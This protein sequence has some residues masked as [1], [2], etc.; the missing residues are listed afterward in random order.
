MS[1]F[2]RSFTADHNVFGL[3]M[4]IASLSLL[5]GFA[6]IALQVGNK[7]WPA[8]LANVAYCAVS[9]GSAVFLVP[10]YRAAGL[11]TAFVLGTIVQ[12]LA[13]LVLIRLFIP[14]LHRI[15]NFGFAL[16][17]VG[18]CIGMQLLPDRISTGNLAL[19]GAIFAGSVGCVCW[20]GLVG[21][22]RRL[23]TSLKSRKECISFS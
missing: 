6:G 13:L 9:I 15:V 10:R 2:G 21:P 1:V 20:L 8:L 7:T 23:I 11:A 18:L 16:L 14:G 5:S 4:A 17:S 12:A 3:V 22:L 19:R